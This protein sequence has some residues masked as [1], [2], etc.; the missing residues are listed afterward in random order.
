MFVQ[1]IQRL[2]VLSTHKLFAIFR[3]GLYFIIF[4]IEY[5]KDL[6]IFVIKVEKLVTDNAF[7]VSALG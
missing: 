6:R 7:Q 1:Q 4:F 3:C 5:T 2:P